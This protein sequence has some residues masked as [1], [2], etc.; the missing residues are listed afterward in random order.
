[1]E[2]KDINPSIKPKSEDHVPV[3][4]RVLWGFGGAADNFVLNGVNTLILPIYN[5][6]FGVDAVYIGIAQFIPR[7]ID[8]ITDPL[9]GNISD[10]TRSRWGRRRPYIFIGALLTALVFAFLWTPPALLGL[11]GMFIYLT[12]G[13][14]LYSITYTI[15]VV[16]Y[17]AL[18]YELTTD[19]NEKTRVLAWRMYIGLAAG[20]VVPWLYKLSFVFGSP[21]G[22]ELEGV[23]YV[24]WIVAALILI[25]GVIPALFCREKV[26]VT[27][28]A[29]IDLKKAVVSAFRNKAFVVL[30]I[31]N[32]IIKMGVFM[33][34]PFAIYVN[35]YYICQGDSSFA[36]TVVG[37]SQMTMNIAGYLSLILITWYSARVGKT[38]AMITALIIAIASYVGLW[39]ALT[40]E[41]PYLQLIPSF[42]LGISLYGSWLLLG[43]MLGDICNQD[44]YQSGLRREGMYS[45]V[46]SF[47]DKLTFALITILTSLLLK[48]SG[49][50]VGLEVQSEQ[51][52]FNL[53]MLYVWVQAIG[54]FLGMLL[55]FFYPLTR[56]RCEEIHE[57]LLAI[58]VNQYTNPDI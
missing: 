49:F 18:G 55:F 40:P 34:F 17:T 22:G 15:F 28:Q 50:V 27:S 41:A 38:K 46:F 9:M 26:F 7:I 33:T 35:T 20:L 31:A 4:K 45:A 51:T 16:P 21:E 52:L 6:G 29:K 48:A 8:A 53:R 5:I 19:Y 14:I 43:S 37:A 25:A 13:L 47:T 58:R 30:V 44:E 56:Q 57:G 11:R 24:A 42:F 36:A 1:M 3:S 32:L 39:F 54:L 12:V 10:N 2:S 23:R